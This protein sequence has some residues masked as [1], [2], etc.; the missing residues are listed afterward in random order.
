MNRKKILE[1]EKTKKHTNK[2]KD[3][4]DGRRRQRMTGEQRTKVVEVRT[5]RPIYISCSGKCEH[6]DRSG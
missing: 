1:E 2:L 5:T 4:D 3:T 6:V